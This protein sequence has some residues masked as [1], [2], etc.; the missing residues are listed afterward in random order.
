MNIYSDDE[1]KVGGIIDSSKAKLSIKEYQE[2]IAVGPLVRN[3]EVGD[4]VK[5]NPT[6]YQV[7][8]YDENSVQNDIQKYE[9]I[10]SY[11][12]K[13]IEM[14]HK[15]YLYLADSDIEYVIEEYEDEPESDIIIPNTDIVTLS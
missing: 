1:L 11:R 10:D 2:V 15:K 5:I 3:I 8:K 14:D 13:F 9:P 12:F 7:R 4:I 6:R